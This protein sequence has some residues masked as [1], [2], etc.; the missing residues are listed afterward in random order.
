[1]GL[2]MHLETRLNI[3]NS[4]LDVGFQAGV[5][6][7]NRQMDRYGVDYDIRHSAMITFVDYNFRYWK[8]VAPF[9]GLGMG[10][11]AVN[12]TSFW[13]NSNTGRET[14]DTFYDRLYLVNTRV[15]VEFYNHFRITLEYKYM[16]KEYSHLGISIGFVFGGGYK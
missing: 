15:G 2:Q 16:K 7:F 12:Y 9:V 8:R 5:A 10:Y 4:P 14:D 13:R 1:M 11:A 3:E 6:S